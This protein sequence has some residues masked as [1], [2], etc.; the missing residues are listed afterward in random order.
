[1]NEA[2]TDE[3]AIEVK[4]LSKAFRIPHERHT[5]IK[6]AALNIFRPKS[7]QTFEALNDV[8]FE[9]RKGEFFGIIG[10]NGSGKSTLLKILA[11]IYMPGGG[12]LKVNGKLSP[13]LELGVG[14]NPELT[15]RENVFLGGA[16]LGLSKKDIEKNFDNIIG[17][18]ELEEFVDMKF[19]NF[20]SGMQVRLAFALSIHAH[21]EILLMDE[22]LAVGDSNFQAKCLS[23]FSKY[24]RQAK[25]IVLVSH[26]TATIQRHCD[27]AMLLES[28]KIRI[29]GPPDEVVNEY[30]L[31][32]MAE[33]ES[34]T[35]AEANQDTKED[36]SQK[37]AQVINV[38]LLDRDG[39]EKKT[40]QTGDDLTI[41]VE[42]ERVG[43][44]AEDIHVAI[45]I[46]RDDGFHILSCN[47]SIDGHKI[48][49]DKI[50]M[51]LPQIPLLQG[52]YYL[53]VACFGDIEQSLFD[54]R[55]RA[56]T[57]QI[58]P[59]EANSEY[60]GIVNLEHKWR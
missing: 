14:F 59:A 13:F 47:T 32:N 54:L 10:K 16:V 19:K 48:R 31:R 17:F 41:K 11:G 43:K 20:S 39:R 3:I 8:S 34:R 33:T 38:Q 4:N 35:A 36:S 6:Q 9:I 21:A 30:M 26:S 7:Y 29:I 56:R 15:A 44:T 45:G 46:Y 23:E 22:V 57:F 27:R 18:A 60:K 37:K 58:F 40:F 50:E 2:K 55:K 5:T 42:F 52:G 24:K 28:G 25:T 49:K 12:T 1:M 51:T 53:N